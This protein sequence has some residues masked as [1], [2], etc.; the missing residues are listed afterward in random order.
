MIAHEKYPFNGRPPH[1]YMDPVE[2]SD[3]VGL[4]EEVIDILYD[5]ASE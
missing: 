2:V 4:C 5:R 1:E 3:L